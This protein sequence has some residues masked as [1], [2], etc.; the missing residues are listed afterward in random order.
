MKGSILVVS[1]PSGSGKTSLAKEVCKELKDL[2]YFS[3]S[4]TTR[5]IRDGEKD[6]VDYFFINKEEF[7]KD[8]EDGYFLEWAKVHGNFYGTSKKQINE[9]LKKGKIVFLDIDVQGYESV[10]KEYANITTG[11]FITTPSE[12]VLKERLLN[13]NTET[14]SSLEVRLT[15]ALKEMQ[16]IDEYDYLLIND[17]FNKAKEFLR[18]V[19][20]ASLI[21]TTKYD[22]KK[23]IK[24]WRES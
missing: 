3:I 13:R 20:L 11:V 10:K 19:A 12:K 18:A 17:D 7:L 23:F 5:K 4:T 9:A 15:N 22:I 6:G 1:G 16:K 24:K 14:K 21:K 2:A 8:V